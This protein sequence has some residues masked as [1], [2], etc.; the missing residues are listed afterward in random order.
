MVKATP[1][2]GSLPH[3][4]SSAN[5]K[6]KDRWRTWVLVSTAAGAIGHAIVFIL[7][8]AWEIVGRTNPR[9]IEM[10]QIDPILSVG[11]QTDAGDEAIPA[12]VTL[13]EVE[14]ETTEAGQGGVVEVDLTDLI[15]V[16]GIPGPSIAYPVLPR[17]V[18]GEAPPPAPPLLLEEV[19]PLT[20]RLAGASI[21][22]QLPVIRNPT[23]LQRFLRS[24]YNPVYQEPDGNGHV[25]VAMWI[26]ERG[27]VEWTAISQSS[28]FPM[29]DEIAL[30]VFNDIA[31]F[32]PA[33][34]RG[35]RV[36]VS[37]V[38]SV[39]FTARW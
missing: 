6:W 20:P 36:P 17:A 39:P 7:V 35:Q 12:E 10:V 24:R 15:E 30:E 1:E 3:G 27:A 26:N 28:G 16:F 4:A 23:V 18:Y 32:T 9:G 29:V 5:E 11:A 25:S 8:P 22:V 38:I 13:E 19:T 14:I 21:A 37:V 2:S 34:S 33:R 31:L